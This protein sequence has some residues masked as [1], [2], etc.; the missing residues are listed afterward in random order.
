MTQIKRSDDPGGI[1]KLSRP[2]PSRWCEI[3]KSKIYICYKIM[4]SLRPKPF[5]GTFTIQ[6][7]N[8]PPPYQ[9]YLSIPFLEDMKQSENSSIIHIGCIAIVFLWILNLCRINQ[10]IE[11]LE[12]NVVVHEVCQCWEPWTLPLYLWRTRLQVFW[13]SNTIVVVMMMMMMMTMMMTMMML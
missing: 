4:S 10:Q 3:V 11:K 5:T 13:N 12:F 7:E 1:S 9:V 6:E 2:L 8:R